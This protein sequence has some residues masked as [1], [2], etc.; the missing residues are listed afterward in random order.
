MHS[1]FRSF[2]PVTLI[3]ISLLFLACNPDQKLQLETNATIAL[4]GNNLGSRMMHYP[5]FETEL[6][7]R[8][9]EKDLIIRNL[10]DPADTPGFRPRSGTKDPWAFPGAQDFQDE[11]ATPSGSEGFLEKPDQWLTR[12]KADVV[13]GFFGFNESF[14][15]KA[16]LDN[17]KAELDAWMKRIE[18]QECN[19]DTIA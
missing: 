11:Y 8:F 16:G 10:C 6:Y 5:D 17:F 2:R 9:P 13:I 4:V 1:F 19:G 7:A 12:L 14:Q 3:L 15:G 18:R